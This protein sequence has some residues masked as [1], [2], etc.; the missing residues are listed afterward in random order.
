MVIENAA[1]LTYDPCMMKA[2]KVRFFGDEADVKHTSQK[3][4]GILLRAATIDI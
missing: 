2:F 4:A 1:L 3:D